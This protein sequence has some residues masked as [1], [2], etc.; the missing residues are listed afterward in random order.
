MGRKSLYGEGIV[1]CWEGY[2]GYVRQ[3]FYLLFEDVLT[4]FFYER[5][6]FIVG[7]FYYFAYL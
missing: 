5:V 2:V 7:G 4:F 6:D 1:G 3:R